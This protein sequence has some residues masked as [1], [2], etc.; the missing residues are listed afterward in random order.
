M[1]ARFVIGILIVTILVLLYH[2]HELRK[3]LFNTRQDC[4]TVQNALQYRDK[5][6]ADMQVALSEAPGNPTLGPPQQVV[7]AMED[8]GTHFEHPAHVDY[9]TPRH[10]ATYPEYTPRSS[11]NVMPSNETDSTFA[12]PF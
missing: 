10:G 1:D 3:V 8:I 7:P 9:P 12:A 5:E 4:V 2:V 11:G 6:Y